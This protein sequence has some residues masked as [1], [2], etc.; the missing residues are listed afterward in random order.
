MSKLR[1][2]V[3]GCGKIS[4]MHAVSIL[5]QP[6]AELVCVCDIRKDRAEAAAQEYGCA[7]CTD[8]KKMISDYELDAVHICTPHY[9][10]PEMAVYALEHGLNVLCEKPMAIKYEDALRMQNAAKAS[11]KALVI[12]FQNRFNPGSL[13]IKSAL[14]SGSLGRIISARAMVTWS[15]SDDYY[16]KSDWKGTWDKEGGGVIID[17]AIHTLDLMNWYI[18]S[19]LK[20]V[21]ASLHNRAHSI[22]KVE[23]S[24]EGYIQYENGTNACF[25]AINYYGYDAP[26]ELELYC[27]NGIAKL[28]GEKATLTYNDGRVFSQDRNPNILFEF[29]NAKQYWG[30]GHMMEIENFYSSLKKGTNP[31]NL[32]PEVMQTHQLVCSIY[33]SFRQGRD[34]VF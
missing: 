19:P 31:R 34:I 21:S 11:G 8:W 13:L 23:D 17:Q 5:K 9:L 10:H 20:K 12:S 24:A 2:G 26:V 33:D 4:V 6:D 30:V 29:R 15:R 7:W 22:I 27:E 1:A 28:V 32:C 16:S 18:D 14:E 3:I 25:F